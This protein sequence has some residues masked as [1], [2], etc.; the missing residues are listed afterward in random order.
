MAAQYDFHSFNVNDTFKNF[1]VVPDYQREYVWKDCKEVDQLLNDV[2]DAYEDDPKKEYFLGSIVVYGTDTYNELIDGQQRLTTLFIMLCAFRNWYKKLSLPTNA[3]DQAILSSDM[4]QDGINSVNKFHLVLQYEDSKDIIKNIYNDKIPEK[5]INDNSSTRIY[6]AYIYIKQFIQEKIYDDKQKLGKFFMYFFKKLIYIQI[7][8]PNINDSL[9]IFETI[10]DRGVG[11]NPMDLLKNLIFRKVGL[12]HFSSV[13]EKWQTLVKLLEDN[14]EKPLRFLRYFIMSNYPSTDNKSTKDENIVREDEIYIWI[15]DHIKLCQLNT[16]PVR[17][18]DLLID[19]AKCY[20]NFANG[21]DANGMPNVF[22]DNILKLSGYAFHQHLI[23]LLAARHFNQNMFNTLCQAIEVYL[24]YYLFTR[25][26]AK[27]FEKQ[28]AKWNLYISRIKTTEDL[29]SFIQSDVKPLIDKKQ[30][31]YKSRFLGFSSNDWQRYRVRY[32]LSKIAQY[33]N[34]SRK[35][36]FNQE[37]LTTYYSGGI[38]IEHIMP[39]TPLKE[40]SVSQ[41]KYQQ[42]ISMLGNLTL[43]EKS[44]N[45]SI[46]NEPFDK[47]VIE[48]GKSNIYLTKSIHQFDTVGINTAINRA[49]EKLKTYDHWDESTINERQLMLYKISLDIWKI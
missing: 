16:Y 12:D 33:I 26:Q 21:K 22:L 15:N 1:Y 38:E 4:A 5:L 45:A 41:E 9:K 27:I 34:D 37:A 25:E 20:V 29:S 43:I 35:G 28:F 48:Y 47:K 19:N 40:L 32:I 14:H 10:N 3:I 18:V 2:Y 7:K 46:H 30:A 13:K 24:F 49:N 44:I 6:K 31:E 8:S 36:I 42:Q 39:Q 17:F 23:I 11:L